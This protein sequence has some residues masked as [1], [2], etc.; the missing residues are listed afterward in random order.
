[1]DKIIST[2]LFTVFFIAYFPALAQNQQTGSQ[3]DSTKIFISADV[4]PQFPGGDEAMLQFLQEQLNEINL[5]NKPEGISILTI[6]VTKAGEIKDITVVKSLEP[7][8]DAAAIEA[9]KKMPRWTPGSHKGQ[10][11][12]VRFTLPVRFGKEIQQKSKT[13]QKK[14]R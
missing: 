7:T 5:D 2:I 4:A 8:L 13:K 12:D 11:E 3:S 14:K 1:M 6:V 9:V 10:I